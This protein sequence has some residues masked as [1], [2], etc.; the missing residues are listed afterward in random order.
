MV[1]MREKNNEIPKVCA[2]LRC[3]YSVAKAA[4]LLSCWLVE[5]AVLNPSGAA[6]EIDQSRWEMEDPGDKF[7]LKELGCLNTIW[8][9]QFSRESRT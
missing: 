5:N 1:H 8:G 4:K 2:A 3:N 9:Q 7:I 6:P